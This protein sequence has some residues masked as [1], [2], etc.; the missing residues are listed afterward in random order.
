VTSLDEVDRATIPVAQ[1]AVVLTRRAL[2]LPGLAVVLPYVEGQLRHKV[3]NPLHDFSPDLHQT[4]LVN[5]EHQ[6][7]IKPPEG[8]EI[9]ELVMRLYF[10]ETSGE[11]KEISKD[12][13]KNGEKLRLPKS[14]HWSIRRELH[15]EA[16]LR[17]FWNLHE[18]KR[19]RLIEQTEEK[20]LSLRVNLPRLID[21]DIPDV[22]HFPSVLPSLPKDWRPFLP[23]ERRGL[24]FGLGTI[25]APS[26]LIFGDRPPPA[27][28]HFEGYLTEYLEQLKYFASPAARKYKDL[29]ILSC[30]VLAW[31]KA[32]QL[33][34]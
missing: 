19:K 8:M 9:E 15:E 14:T 11:G 27:I 13:E 4:F 23:D 16:L 3:F 24:A 7:P 30:T 32:Q 1:A 33:A 20:Y 28:R 10:A 34:P 22:L 26:E 17:D 6:H 21:K 25:R 5:L 12:K 31:R 29:L 18:D 2:S